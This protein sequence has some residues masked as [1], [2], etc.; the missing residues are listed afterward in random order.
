MNV[1]TILRERQ[2]YVLIASTILKQS[3]EDRFSVNYVVRQ[4]VVFATGCCKQG[5]TG[6]CGLQGVVQV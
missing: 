4:A 1:H 5:Q 2:V 6:G 3:K